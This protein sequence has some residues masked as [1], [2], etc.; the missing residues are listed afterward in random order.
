LNIRIYHFRFSP[1]HWWIFK[2]CFKKKQYRKSKKFIY[3]A[4]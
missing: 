2:W 4:V 3:V 1:L